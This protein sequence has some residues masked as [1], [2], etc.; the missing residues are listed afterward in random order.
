MPHHFVCVCVCARACLFVYCIPVSNLYEGR[1]SQTGTFTFTGAKRNAI[2]V[3][4]HTVVS[5]KCV[6]LLMG[7][8]HAAGQPGDRQSRRQTTALVRARNCEW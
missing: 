6:L 3:V 4:L 1:S 7:G 5:G 8:T 2:M